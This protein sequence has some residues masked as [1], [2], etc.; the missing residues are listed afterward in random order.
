MRKTPLGDR[1]KRFEKPSEKVE[2]ARR[3]TKRFELVMGSCGGA[4]ACLAGGRPPNP[5]N[6]KKDKKN[7]QQ[8]V[9]CDIKKIKKYV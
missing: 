2:H 8:T 3:F 6:P 4:T 5:P 7:A 1:F 9:L